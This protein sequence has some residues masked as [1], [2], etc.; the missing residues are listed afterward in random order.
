MCWAAE[1][2]KLKARKAGA[3]FSDILTIGHGRKDTGARILWYGGVG[4]RRET[5]HPDC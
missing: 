3:T 4:G 1:M 2:A 5:T